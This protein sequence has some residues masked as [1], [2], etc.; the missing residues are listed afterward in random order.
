MT[1]ATD[2]PPAATPFTDAEW[3]ALQADD[4]S[5]GTAVVILMLGIFSTGVVLYAAVAYTV[6]QGV[7]FL[8]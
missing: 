6:W 2:H 7:G 4:L 3:A 5:A 1:V 8:S